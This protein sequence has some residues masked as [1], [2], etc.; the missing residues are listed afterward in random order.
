MAI[1]QLKPV[2]PASRFTSRPD[3]S[4]ITTSKPE[5]SLVRKLNKTGGRN[6]RGRITSRRRGGGHKRSYRVID[7]KR[8]KF[9]VK[10]TVETIEYDPNRSSRIALKIKNKKI[11]SQIKLNVPTFNKKNI[12]TE[13]KNIPITKPGSRFL[14]WPLD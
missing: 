5:K 4:E 3:F 9:D 14:K 7:F 1:R 10:A 12:P 8:N 6:N 11:I 2:T 13:L